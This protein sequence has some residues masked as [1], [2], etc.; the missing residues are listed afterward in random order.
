[1]NTTTESLGQPNRT[2]RKRFKVKWLRLFA[3]FFLV[4]V[5]FGIAV[6]MPLEPSGKFAD[7]GIGC[8][9]MAFYEFS[10]GKV[11]L[12]VPT[13]PTSFETN[14]LGTYGKENGQ[15]VFTISSRGQSPKFK[16]PLRTTL[17]QIQFIGDETHSPKFQRL[18]FTPK[19]PIRKDN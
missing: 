6:T 14:L 13:G 10:G 11:R 19:Y 4:A 17:F 16:I 3:V 12:I 1:M 9:G 5:V 18:Y 7:P 2:S 8:I 15:W